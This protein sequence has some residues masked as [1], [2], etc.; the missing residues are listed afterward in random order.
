MKRLKKTIH[1]VIAEEIPTG[2]RVLDLGC[3][4]GELLSYLISQKNVKGHGVD[5]DY[6]AL[7]NCIEKGLSVIQL[8]LNELPLDF[9]DN[10]FDMVILNQT[11]QEVFHPDRIILEMLRIGKEAILGF[12]NFGTLNVRLKLLFNG[13]MPVTDELPYYWFNTPNIHLLTLKDF[14]NFCK[15]NKI[16]LKKEIYLKS[17]IIKSKNKPN[18]Y[19]RIKFLPNLRAELV[20]VKIYKK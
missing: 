15:V 6:K 4:N 12:P 1:Q 10:S 11:I 14:K 2:Y 8:D 20:V 9:S 13:K 5:I 3:G 19:K 7:I 16:R 18:N 17:K